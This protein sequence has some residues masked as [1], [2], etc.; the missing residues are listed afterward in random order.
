M[1]FQLSSLHIP[2]RFGQSPQPSPPRPPQVLGGEAS[3][4]R[5]HQSLTPLL[6]G[7]PLLASGSR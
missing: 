1:S 5:S 2:K 4:G 3:A 6:T 7:L